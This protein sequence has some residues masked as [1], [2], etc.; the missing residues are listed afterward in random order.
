ML[1]NSGADYSICHIGLLLISAEL[2]AVKW[3]CSNLLL[4]DLVQNELLHARSFFLFASSRIGIIG[5]VC[6]G[7][8][9]HTSCA[10]QSRYCF[11]LSVCAKKIIGKLLSEISID[12]N[13]NYDYISLAYDL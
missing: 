11:C 13:V 1:F 3:L 8:K 7:C 12:K 9:L 2:N 4:S 6:I 10:E 5:K